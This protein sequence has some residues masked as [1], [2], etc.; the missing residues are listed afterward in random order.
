[1]IFLSRFSKIDQD[2]LS[3]KNKQDG[4]SIKNKQ[5]GLSIKN[6]Q[7]WPIWSFY[8]DLARMTKM[9]YLS[10]KSKIDQD[11]LYFMI[12]KNNMYFTR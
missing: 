10:R 7:D 4:L 1:M 5:D 2:G 9:V 12:N 8:Q 3:I 11:G 6:K